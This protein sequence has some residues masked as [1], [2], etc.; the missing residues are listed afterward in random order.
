MPNYANSKIYKLTGTNLDGNSIT[1]YGSTTKHY[2]TSRLS[3]HK[4]EAKIGNNKS[5]QQVV[6]CKDCQIT[7]I[8][9]F[10]CGSKDE[11]TARERVYVENNPCINKNMPGRSQNESKKNWR[12]N[13]P[14]YHKEYQRNWRKKNKVSE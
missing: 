3:Q 2:L 13:N 11:L 4:Y 10:P 7:L 1:Y 14:E 9:L 5:S 12:I 6:E 8:E